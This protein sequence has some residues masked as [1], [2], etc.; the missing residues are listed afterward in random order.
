MSYPPLLTSQFNT[1][2]T[3]FFKSRCQILLFLPSV[4]AYLF[5]CILF[6]LPLFSHDYI[7]TSILNDNVDLGFELFSNESTNPVNVFYSYFHDKL[8]SASGL[9]NINSQKSFETDDLFPYINIKV[10]DSM[11][12]SQLSK[13]ERVMFEW[14]T[15][16]GISSKIDLNS[17]DGFNFDMKDIAQKLDLNSTTVLPDF[18]Q[19]KIYMDPAQTDNSKISMNMS[20]PKLV[21]NNQTKYCS[22]EQEIQR[23]P[24]T[25]TPYGN[26]RLDV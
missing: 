13:I 16:D 11:N 26:N 2:G 17:T 5:M 12:N 4:C 24:R 3:A 25:L 1:D 10:E 20:Q 7:E 23:F 22:Y 21:C 19:I 6:V 9:K 14:V 18:F 8:F 15:Y